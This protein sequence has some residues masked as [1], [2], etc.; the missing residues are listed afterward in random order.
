M[1]GWFGLFGVWTGGLSGLAVG[2]MVW[3]GEMAVKMERLVG[4]VV[5]KADVWCTVLLVG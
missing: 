1:V 5:E 3:Y 2:L 4:G